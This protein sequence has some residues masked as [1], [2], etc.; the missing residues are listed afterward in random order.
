MMGVQ[1]LIPG[2]KEQAKNLAI[3]NDSGI[4]MLSNGPGQEKPVQ[5]FSGDKQGYC[6]VHL[7]N[8]ITI[9]MLHLFSTHHLVDQLLP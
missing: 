3:K 6:P 5:N 7:S 4:T 1:L 9:L 2:G 8:G